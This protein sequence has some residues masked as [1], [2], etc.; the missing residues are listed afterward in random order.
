MKRPKVQCRNFVNDLGGFGELKPS[1]LLFLLSHT[2]LF[3]LYYLNYLT[4]SVSVDIVIDWLFYVNVRLT[5]M[6][7]LE[8]SI[9]IRC[10]YLWYPPN[11]YI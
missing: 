6:D 8:L 10:V 7:F 5:S 9:L 3:V 11:L 1:S 2:N 4:V